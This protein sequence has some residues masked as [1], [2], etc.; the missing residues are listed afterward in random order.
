MKVLFLVGPHASG[1]TFTAKK[2]VLGKEDIKMVDTGPIMRSIHNNVSPN[3]TMAEWVSNLE[4]Q[5]GKD[6]TSHL[7]ST[8]IGKV[9]MDLSCDKFILIGFRTI[10][11]ILYTIEHLNIEDYS[12]LYVDASDELLFNNYLAREKKNISFEEFKRYLDNELKSGLINLKRNALKNES[13][14]YFYKLSNED[15]LEEKI[16]SHFKGYTMKKSKKGLI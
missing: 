9:M 15:P 12:V 8:E 4:K 1:K 11:G 6:A 13:I 14:D 3:T 7:I 10:E 16:D 5:Y 2:Y